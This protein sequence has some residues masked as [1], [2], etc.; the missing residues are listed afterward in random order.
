[1]L[2]RHDAG[3]VERSDAV[4]N[5]NQLPT[6]HFDEYFESLARSP[7]KAKVE[8]QLVVETSRGCWWGA[9]HHCTFCGLNGDTMAFRSK[10]PERAFAE[11][12]YLSRRHQTRRL[13]CV[14][15][16]LD[17]RYI[18]TLF[19]DLPRAAMIRALLRGEGQPPLRSTGETRCGRGEADSAWDRELQQ[20]GASAHGQGMF[21]PTEHPTVALV[22]GAGH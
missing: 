19:P 22:P 1:M 11:M 2:G 8:G 5:L 3:E 12:E 4:Q 13:G 16:I 10:T 18:D 9:K 15:N 7:L 6:P 14:D 20:S 21:G 17:L